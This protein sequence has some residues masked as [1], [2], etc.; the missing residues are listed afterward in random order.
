MARRQY[1]NKVKSFSF[2]FFFLSSF[3]SFRCLGGP[4][5]SCEVFERI[6]LSRFRKRWFG[7][8]ATTGVLFRYFF[9]PF[10]VGLLHYL[11]RDMLDTLLRVVFLPLMSQRGYYR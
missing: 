4:S 2:L 8:L 1:G 7:N 5:R 11:G 9:F 3:C 10:G 6:R